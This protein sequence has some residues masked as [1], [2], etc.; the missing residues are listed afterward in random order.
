MLVFAVQLLSFWRLPIYRVR[1]FISFN[2]DDDDGDD[3]F[4]DII[5]EHVFRPPS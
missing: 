2:D 1:C 5:M 3:E 4:T